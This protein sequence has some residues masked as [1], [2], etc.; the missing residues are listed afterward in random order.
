VHLLDIARQIP[1]H[2]LDLASDFSSYSEKLTQRDD[3][4]DLLAPA[5][6]I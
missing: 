4:P 3:N 2:A 1:C 6:R 5:C